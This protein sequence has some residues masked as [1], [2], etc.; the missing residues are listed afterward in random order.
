M[1]EDEIVQLVAARLVDAIRTA[2]YAHEGAPATQW[3]VDEFVI[4]CNADEFWDVVQQA[5]RERL[6]GGKEAADTSN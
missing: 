1:D 4:D 5:L 6:A 2:I 3:Y